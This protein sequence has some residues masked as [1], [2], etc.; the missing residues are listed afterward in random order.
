MAREATIGSP[1]V[2]GP[3]AAD[4][5]RVVRAALV[6]DLGPGDVTSSVLLAAGQECTATFVLKERGVVCGLGIAAEVFALLDE[7][8]RVVSL[9]ADG[10]AL[11]APAEIARVEGPARAVLTG[12]RTALNLLG[13]LSGIATLTRRYVEAIGGGRATLLDTRKTAPGLRALDKYAVRC[14]G[15]TNHRLGLYDAILIKDN[16]KRLA[17]G[18]GAATR[19]ARAQAPP[20]LSVEV[21]CETLAEVGEALAAGA[22]RI[23]LDNMSLAELT[24][25][26]R[27]VAGRAVLEASGGVTLDTVR[28]IAGTGVDFVSVGALTHS[29][30]SL[31]I[32]MEVVS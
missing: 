26:V 13:R 27:L 5:A 18:V 28:A 20:G 7:R 8:V 15:G 25:A 19:R 14:G 17:G 6:E 12:E 32:S 29:P 22:A 16:H 21:E 24:D 1:P 3:P 2:P 10:D 11:D 4:V 31:D 23:L 30:R 9:A